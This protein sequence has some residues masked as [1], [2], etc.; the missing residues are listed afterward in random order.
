MK[1]ATFKARLS[2]LCTILGEF[3]CGDGTLRQIIQTELEDN[4]GITDSEMRIRLQE[5]AEELRE[6]MSENES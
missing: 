2:A 6:E 1:T 4:P 3:D 5:F